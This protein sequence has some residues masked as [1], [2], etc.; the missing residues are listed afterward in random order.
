MK[1]NEAL[2]ALYLEYVNDYL[3]VD[4]FATDHGIHSTDARRIISMGKVYHEDY[5]ADPDR[6]TIAVWFRKFEDGDVIALWDDGSR[7]EWISS[8]MHVGQHS[9][10]SKDLVDTL[11]PATAGE[12]GPL[13][14]ELKGRGYNVTFAE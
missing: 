6:E 3:T 2:R 9:E 5:A 11:A 7:K 1:A 8:Y 4:K 10:A 13:L 14:N 12:Y